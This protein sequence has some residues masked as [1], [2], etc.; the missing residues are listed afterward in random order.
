MRARLR[1]AVQPF[2]SWLETNRLY[3]QLRATNGNEVTIMNINGVS[4]ASSVIDIGAVSATDLSTLSTGG[5]DA[6]SSPA[7]QASI[8]KPGELF[9][10]LQQ[11]EQ[12]DPDKFKQI[13][14]SIADNLRSAA[15]QA[16]G[17]GSSFLD[18][19]ADRFDQA[20]QTGDLSSLQPQQSPEQQQ[21]GAV[22]GHHHGGHHGHH[23]GGGG[24]AIS[25]IFDDA[26]NQVNAALTDAANGVAT[27]TPTTS[28]TSSTDTTS[29]T[30][31][32]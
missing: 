17:Q 14:G 27:T 28:T 29:S 9:G 11:L 30:S 20:A 26:L 25:S 32:T 13:V 4:N 6:T 22:S 23:G 18:K 8:S 2:L 16:G 10:K 19:L 15:Q 21:N 3:A 1:A 24:G 7:A 12:Q 5:T 31:A